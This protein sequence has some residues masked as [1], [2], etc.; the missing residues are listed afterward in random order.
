MVTLISNSKRVSALI[1]YLLAEGKGGHDGSVQRNLYLTGIGLSS[2]KTKNVIK[3]FNRE[4]CHID[5]RKHQVEARHIIVSPSNKEIPYTTAN[6]SKFAEMVR[7]YIKCVYP[8]RRALICIQADGKGFIDPNG[9]I[10]KILH[11]HVCLS[12]ADILEYKGVK[13]EKTGFRFLSKSFDDFVTAKYNITLDKGRD[14]PRRRYLKDKLITEQER[15]ADGKFYFYQD[16]IIDRINRCIYA[17]DSLED[18]YDNLESFGLSVNHKTRKSGEE[19]QTY[20]LH[21][22]DNISDFSKDRTGNIKNIAKKNQLPALRS[23][24]QKGLDI[25]NIEAKILQK[26]NSNLISETYQDSKAD[27]QHEF[28]QFCLNNELDYG[29]DNNFNQ[30]KFNEAMILYKKKTEDSDNFQCSNTPIPSSRKDISSKNKKAEISRNAA[31]LLNLIEE[32]EKELKKTKQRAEKA[33]NTLYTEKG[34]KNYDYQK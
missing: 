10:E 29:Q 12:D 18:F 25:K 4:L 24:K 28:Y 16:D 21:S 1:T 2:F 8:N 15:D 5:R 14:M 34:D 19:Y 26:N 17:S 7:E 9:K 33:Q 20:Y 31:V 11:A 23:Y 3:A 30:S 22:L 32:E 27:E 13:T 6:A